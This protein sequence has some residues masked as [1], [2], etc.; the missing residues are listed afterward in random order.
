ME[1]D[2][3]VTYETVER[4]YPSG[5]LPSIAGKKEFVLSEKICAH[6]MTNYDEISAWAQRFV[7]IDEVLT[8]ALL[9][10]L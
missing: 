10:S 9:V 4:S 5:S 3:G 1:A 8:R 2:R 7:P 6:K